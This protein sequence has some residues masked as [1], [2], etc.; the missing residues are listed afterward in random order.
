MHAYHHQ[1]RGTR[2]DYERYLQGMDASMQQKVALTAAH[3]LGRGWLADMGM[4]SGTGSEA[5]AALYPELRV[6]GVDISPEMVELA[7]ERYKRP[8]LD[9]RVGD[10]GAAC[11]EDESLDVVFNSSVLHHVTTF[12]GYDKNRAADA[13]ANQVK[14]L[15]VDGSLIIRDFLRPEP[16]LVRLELPEETVPLLE[17]FAAEFRYLLPEE[18]RGFSYREVECDKRGRR[19]FEMESLHAVEFILRKDYTADWETEVLEEYTYFTQREFEE[20][21][22]EQ[23]LRIL[24]S[25]PIRNPWIIR[26]RFEGQFLLKDVDGRSLEFPPTNYLIVGEKVEP[27]DDVVVRASQ[28]SVSIGYLELCYYRHI[29]SGAI[30]DLIRRPNATLD[31][32]P[33]YR[34]HDEVFVIACKSYPRPLLSLCSERLDGGLSPIYVTEPIVVTQGDKPIAQTVEEAL[35]K[36]AGIPPAALKRFHF[37]STSYPSPGGLQEEVRAVFVEVEPTPVSTGTERVRAVAARQLL[38]AA[39]VGGLPDARLELHVCELL[40]RLGESLGSWIGEQLK[41]TVQSPPPDARSTLPE[42]TPRRAFE[43]NHAGGEFL[44]LGCAEFEALS[45]SGVVVDRHTLEYCRPRKLSLHTAAVILLWKTE[46]EVFVGLVDDDFPAVQCFRGHSNLW[47]TPAWRLPTTVTNLDEMESFTRERI[48]TEHQIVVDD[49]FTL[50]GPYYPSPGA[51]P[52]V[53]FPLACQAQGAT[54]KDPVRNNFPI[55]NADPPGTLWVQTASSRPYLCPTNRSR[56]NTDSR[57]PRRPTPES[58]SGP[59]PKGL[60]WVAMSHLVANF[61][62]LRDGHLKTLLSR[63]SRAV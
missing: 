36:R 5:L 6:T 49:F 27:D 20:L 13:V 17:R 47:V 2:S 7:T 34:Q 32:V 11:F 25:T 48:A 52:E 37:G 55:S 15:K 24:A 50:G 28:E 3:L 4:G 16:G 33:F 41:L 58:Y 19:A 26:N 38:R 40:A 43:R 51:T 10:I 44:H 18:E 30:R 21:F 12:N 29:E 57:A 23:R 63:A 56:A 42:S 8:N 31:V 46:E 53:V 54:A 59:D 9:F 35:E 62:N 45:H 1:Q 39:Q 61:T 60:H 14:Q 22:R